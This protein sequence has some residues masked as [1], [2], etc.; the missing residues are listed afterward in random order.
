MSSTLF[1][2]IINGEIPGTF[3]Y[4]DDLCVAFMTINPITTGHLLLVPIS[5]FDE[6]TD[7]PELLIAHMFVV[8]KNIGKAQ[9]SV[10]DCERVALIIAGYEIPHCHLHLIP[11]NSMAD[12]S[13]ENAEIKNDR[14]E[15]EESASLIIN[16]LRR[17]NIA[18]AL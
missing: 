15:L 16:E 12:L 18:G 6:W 14:R 9:K 2:Q 1:S 5:E 7:L 17:M 3:V 4:R 10:F 11:T 8:A 13:F